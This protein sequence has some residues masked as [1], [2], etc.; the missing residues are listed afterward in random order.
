MHFRLTGRYFRE[1]RMD[2]NSGKQDTLFSGEMFMNILFLCFSF[3]VDFNEQIYGCP[4]YYFLLFLA[5]QRGKFKSL[6]QSTLWWRLASDL[7]IY[8]PCLADTVALS[9]DAAGCSPSVMGSLVTEKDDPC[10]ICFVNFA[11]RDVVPDIV[12]TRCGHRYDLGC[13]AKSFVAQPFGSRRCAICQQNPIPLVNERTGETYLG[14]LFP[15]QAFFDACHSG[16]LL[17]FSLRLVEGI[18]INGST[19]DGH[20]AL[21]MATEGGQFQIARLLIEVGADVNAR[22]GGAGDLS[23]WTALMSAAR[24]GQLEIAR[25]LIENGARVDCA[26]VIGCTALMVAAENGA[27]KVVEFL[28]EKGAEVNGGSLSG[29]TA[30]ISAVHTGQLEVVKFLIKK[31]ARVDVCLRNAGERNGCTALMLA[32]QDGRLDI[33]RL[34]IEN[35]A[36]VNACRSNA[37][38]FNGWTALMSAAQTGQIEV[39]RLLIEKGANV[40]ACRTNAGGCSGWSALMSAAYYGQLK[41]VEFLLANGSDVGAKTANGETAPMLAIRNNHRRISACFS[42][43]SGAARAN[44]K[45]CLR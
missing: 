16:N 8:V 6:P 15:D 42:S 18:N 30:L 24:R 13:I 23:G 11:G 33:A 4:D 34:L 38:R 7:L 21:M 14:S 22:R 3:L 9:M 19:S 35:G 45:A 41:M 39:A 32:A 28:V 25:L 5:G 27:L 37:D 10:P 17:L 44:S 12:K 1:C 31:G 2:K 43:V 36:S 26:T 20:T 40:N 29:A